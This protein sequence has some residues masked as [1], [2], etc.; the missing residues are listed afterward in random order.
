MQATHP[1][2]SNTWRPRTISRD[3][4]K[5]EV[6]V[7]WDTYPPTKLSLIPINLDIRVDPL[8]I[9]LFLYLFSVPKYKIN[10]HLLLEP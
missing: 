10:A 5:Y 6:K 3:W 8:Q 7:P 1:S 2:L 4:S 9:Q